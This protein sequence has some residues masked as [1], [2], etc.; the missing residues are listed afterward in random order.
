MCFMDVLE[1][2]LNPRGL[3]TVP[4]RAHSFSYVVCKA[5]CGFQVQ[6]LGLLH[7]RIQSIWFETHEMPLSIKY[8]PQ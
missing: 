2:L 4:L 1:M 5:D 8:L 6:N 7:C 3:S